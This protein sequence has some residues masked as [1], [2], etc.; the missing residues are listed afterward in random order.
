MPWANVPYQ[1][2]VDVLLS[3]RFEIELLNFI[4]KDHI[5]T[6]ASWEFPIVTRTE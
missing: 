5:S 6:E 3:Q 1:V 2:F 4:Y